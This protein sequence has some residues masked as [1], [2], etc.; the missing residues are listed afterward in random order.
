MRNQKEIAK[1]NIEIIEFYPHEVN[2]SKELLNGSLKI[3]LVDFGI[4]IMGV[5]VSKRKSIYFF[6]LP[7]RFCDSH[8]TG[9]RIRFPYVVF[10]DPE[11][12]RTLINAIREKGISFIETLLN[13]PERS[14]NFPTQKIRPMPEPLK[15]IDLDNQEAAG[16]KLKEK[17]LKLAEPILKP[18]KKSV[19]KEF[20]DPPKRKSA[21]ARTNSRAMR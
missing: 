4:V 12:Q 17:P 7:G 20:I 9:E 16:I 18:V 21:F 15:G 11:R 10:E 2:E 6:T 3:K 13:D 14:L 19:A 8:D 1:M 5:L